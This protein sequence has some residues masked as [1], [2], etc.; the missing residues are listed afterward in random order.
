VRTWP[1]HRLFAAAAFA[2]VGWVIARR[3]RS[4]EAHPQSRL[5]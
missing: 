5:G 4:A 1:H 2:I 3:G